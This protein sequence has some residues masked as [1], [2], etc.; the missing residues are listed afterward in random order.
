MR[1]PATAMTTAPTKQPDTR[2]PISDDAGDALR[3][4]VAPPGGRWRSL[5]RSP[6]VWIGVVILSIHLVIA[7]IAPWIVPYSPTALD[8]ESLFAPPSQA[9]LFGA[10]QYGRDILTRVALGGRVTLTLSFSAALLAVLLGGFL[11]IWLG[12]EGGLLDEIFMRLIDATLALPGLLLLLTILSVFGGG[13]NVILFSLVLLFV[14]GI[15]RVARAAT[16]DIVPRDFITAA[17]ARGERTSGIVLRELLPN[18]RDILLVE[19]AMRVSWSVVAVSGLAFLGFGVPPGTPDWGLM[20]AENRPALAYAPWC[21]LFPVLA[22]S[23][24]VIGV[25]LTIDGLAKVFGLDRTQGAPA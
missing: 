2:M 3:L 24:L 19:F 8:P 7:L 14:P 12:Y 1:T 23:S 21:T 4:P 9:H 25:N 22:I 10:D 11:G 18:V 20:I 15:V 6:S 17:R 5:P 13:W 16:L